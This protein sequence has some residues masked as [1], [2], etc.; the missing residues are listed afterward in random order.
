MK[1]LHYAELNSTDII[2]FEYKEVKQLVEILD[3]LCYGKSNNKVYILATDDSQND[4]YVTEKY[5]ELQE[6]CL[7]HNLIRLSENVFLQEYDSY[8]SA[9]EVALMMKEASKLCYKKDLTLLN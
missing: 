1:K 8:E 5:L 9:Y 6:L 7:K 2:E 4:V 3:S